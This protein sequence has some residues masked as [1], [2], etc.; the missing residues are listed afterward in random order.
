MLSEAPHRHRLRCA[1]VRV[2]RRCA[3]R[4]ATAR[5]TAR[6]RHAPALMHGSATLAAPCA[7]FVVLLL[8]CLRVWRLVVAWPC[9]CIAIL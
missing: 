1:A 8:A 3:L 9:V 5:R 2:G 6:G 4:C 7:R